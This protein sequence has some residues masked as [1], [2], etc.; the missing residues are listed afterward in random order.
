MQLHIEYSGWHEGYKQKGAEYGIPQ[1]AF[2]LS[3]NM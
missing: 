2:S 3:I 1:N